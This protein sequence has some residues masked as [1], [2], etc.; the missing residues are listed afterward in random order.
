MRLDHG[1]PLTPK[2]L[3]FT[4]DEE[5]TL[6]LNPEESPTVKLMFYMYLYG[7]S[8]N[9]I[10]K[11]LN[12]LGRKSYLG[13]INWTSST[14][15]QVLRNERHCGTVITRKTYTFDYREHVV[16]KN[17]GEKPQSVY[18]NH[19]DPIISIDDYIAVQRML[20]NGYY[21]NR[22]IL[23][24]LR[25]INSGIFKGFTVINPR[26]TG[27]REAEYFKAA[28]SVYDDSDDNSDS[29]LTEFEVEAGDFDLRGFE[30]ARTEL[31]DLNRRP[32]V[33]FERK[34]LKFSSECV[35]K[36]KDNNYV[37]LLFNPITRKFAIRPTEKEN[38][39]AVVISALKNGKYQPKSIPALAFGETVFSLLGWNASYKYRITGSL[40]EQ[41]NEI[42]YIFDAENS[43]AYFKEYVLS[44]SIV[45][46]KPELQP[47]TQTG[48]YIRAI[49]EEWADS[50]GMQFYAHEQPLS[51][52]QS[53]NEKDWKLRL[54]GQLY[55]TCQKLN[56]TDFEVLKEYI[57][58]ALSGV[59][60]E[61]EDNEYKA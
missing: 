4:H 1:I 45:N 50:F 51:V 57:Q 58:Q 6:V 46:G 20:D 39:C 48:K 49:P 26:W 47:L 29:S 44:N 22:N 37:E 61:E 34:Y 5:G 11:T 3:G 23:P 28:Q 25:V 33:T 7:Y 43:E 15:T 53:Q 54:Q 40:Y 16:L 24:E 52:L 56:V 31:F 9:Q 30:I 55:E 10:A 35:K 8:T 60:I 59:I 17:N 36:F 38:R 13:N 19:H 32:Y 42:A 18:L 2:L 12:A 21:K 27:F 41:N 14:V